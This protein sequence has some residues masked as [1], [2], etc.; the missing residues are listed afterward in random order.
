MERVGEEDGWAA[1]A[2]AA[3]SVGKDVLE[4]RDGA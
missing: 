3:E 4:V 1:A 2:A